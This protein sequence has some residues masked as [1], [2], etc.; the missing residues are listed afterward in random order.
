MRRVTQA[1]NS[2]QKRA[3]RCLALIQF[4][5]VITYRGDLNNVADVLWAFYLPDAINGRRPSDKL[6]SPVHLRPVLTGDFNGTKEEIN[7]WPNMFAVHRHTPGQDNSILGEIPRWLGKPF[8]LYSHLIC[9]KEHKILVTDFPT[10]KA[11][12]RKHAQGTIKVEST[13]GN[14]RPDSTQK[15]RSVTWQPSKHFT[16]TCVALYRTS[17]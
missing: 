5:H 2:E 10:S 15:G 14:L 6:N 13:T 8:L 4:A 3:K 11:P 7:K 17:R 16:S 12:T 9:D 1:G